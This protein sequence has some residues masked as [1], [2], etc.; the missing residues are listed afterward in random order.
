MNYS[1][2][3]LNGHLYKRDAWCCS[4]A[5]SQSFYSNQTL[6]KTDTGLHKTDNGHF[7]IVN[8]HL[9]G[10]ECDSK[11][12]FREEKFMYVT[13]FNTRRFID[14]SYLVDGIVT[15]KLELNQSLSHS[16]NNLGGKLHCYLKQLFLSL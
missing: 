11:L 16:K 7:K 5:I 14:N 12:R 8:G 6:Y 1:E 15:G 4:R 10:A 9:P 3:S 13:L 2:L